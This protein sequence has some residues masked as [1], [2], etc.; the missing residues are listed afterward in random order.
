MTKNSKEVE[1][2]NNYRGKFK[3]N[4]KLAP[5]CSVIEFYG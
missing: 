1:N 3:V 2:T 4:K 5:K